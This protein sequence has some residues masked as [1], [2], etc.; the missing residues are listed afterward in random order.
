MKS[1]EELG[2]S[3]NILKAL[4]KKGF[5]EPTPIQERVI[6]LLL[7]EQIDVVGQAQT[8]TGKTAAFGLPLIDMLEEKKII[9]RQ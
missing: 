8:G 1:F 2:L 4:K 6:P 7:T 9:S 3:E 5:E